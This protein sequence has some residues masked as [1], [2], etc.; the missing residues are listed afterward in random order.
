MIVYSSLKKVCCKEIDILL[1]FYIF[2]SGSSV[3]EGWFIF[4]TI[5]GGGQNMWG[6][7]NRLERNSASLQVKCSKEV[8]DTWSYKG[9]GTIWTPGR[10]GLIVEAGK[11][12]KSEQYSWKNMT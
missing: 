3:R 7:K 2:S 4:K 5:L 8:K 12:D 1:K 10:R 6:Q 11:T 9:N